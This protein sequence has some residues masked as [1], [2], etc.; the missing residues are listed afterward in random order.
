MTVGYAG[1]MHVA[2]YYV[3]ASR[4][5]HKLAE[6]MK[7]DRCSQYKLNDR[8]FTLESWSCEERECDC[9]LYGVNHSNIEIVKGC[10]DGNETFLKFN[11]SSLAPC[12]RSIQNVGSGF[13]KDYNCTRFIFIP[14]DTSAR[15]AIR[16]AMY[17]EPIG[18]VGVILS[19]RQKSFMNIPTWQ[20]FMLMASTY[21]ESVLSMSGKSV[22]PPD[23]LDWYDRQL[24]ILTGDGRLVDI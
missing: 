19:S 20:P 5:N 14:K 3:K 4:S 23:E 9:G 13:F 6:T 1:D 10:F 24:L 12:A 11:T 17:L 16:R 8:Y 15:V 7:L 2:D 21:A 22:V 18:K